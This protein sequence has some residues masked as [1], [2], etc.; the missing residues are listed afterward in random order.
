MS[1]CTSNSLR[2]REWSAD[3][4]PLT[5]TFQEPVAKVRTY[6]PSA[7]EGDADGGKKPKATFDAP[8]SV[9]LEIPDEVFIV[10]VVPEGARDPESPSGCNFTP[11]IR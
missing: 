4:R 5:L 11:S 10:E 3:A 7:L 6:L 1:Q 2:S 9:S 8:T